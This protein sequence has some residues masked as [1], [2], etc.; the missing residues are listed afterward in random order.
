MDTSGVR[1]EVER[2][3]DPIELAARNW[4]R[5]GWEDAAGGMAAVTSLMRAHQL[6]LARV[7]EVLRPDALT[8][9]RYEVLMLLIMSR[10]G[11]LPLAVVGSRLQVHP[12]S[13]TGLVN[14]LER[15]GLVARR[16]DPEDGRARRVSITPRGRA[17]AFAATDRLNARVFADGWLGGEGG[18]SLLAVLTDLR[19]VSGD[20]PPD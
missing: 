4:R 17:V 11:E 20:L 18:R 1:P 13:V 8:F 14:R 10:S 19:R 6:L 15:D 9:A 3:V 12:A 7:E 16:T 5:S 2:P